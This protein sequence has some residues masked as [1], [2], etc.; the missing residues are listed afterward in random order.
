[1]TANEN[2]GKIHINSGIALKNINDSSTGDMTGHASG[3]IDSPTGHWA[4]LGERGPEPMFVPKHASILPHGT[5]L[6]GLSGSSS[7]SSSSGGG[8]YGGGSS[9]ASLLA[10]AREMGKE[11]ASALASH[12]TLLSVDGQVLGQAVVQHMRVLTGTRS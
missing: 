7:S 11:I 6:S 5:D 9:H 1:M 2:F 8:S 4:M 12:Q 10:I 3:I